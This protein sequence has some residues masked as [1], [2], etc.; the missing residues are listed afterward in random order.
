MIKKSSGEKTSSGIIVSG[1]CLYYG[2]VCLPGGSNRTVKLYDNTAASG[3]EVES[4]VADANK[5]TDGHSH[6]NPV[7][8]NNGLY[9]SMTGGTVVVFYTENFRGEA[10]TSGLHNYVPKITI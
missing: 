2:F 6:S 7:F 4:F 1:P 9:L 3:T 5:P 8:C 10:G